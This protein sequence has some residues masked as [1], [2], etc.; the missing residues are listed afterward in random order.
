MNKEVLT[1]EEAA[2][3]L[4]ISPRTLREAAV[5]GEVPGRLIARRWRFSRPALHAWLAG[6]DQPADSVRSDAGVLAD[7][8][9]WPEVM[10]SIEA[11][12]EQ[13]RAEAR[14][15][16]TETISRLNSSRSCAFSA[17]R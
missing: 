14:A 15:A 16:S 10:A 7:N 17:L 8:P 4:E 3:F 12:R 13:Q 9:L 1:L 11:E 6:N 5:R 2:Q